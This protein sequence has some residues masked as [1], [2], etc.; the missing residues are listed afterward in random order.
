M[1]WRRHELRKSPMLPVFFARNTQ[2][3]SII[4]KV[5]QPAPAKLAPAAVDRGI[6][7]DAVPR[8]PAFHAA[9][10]RRNDA[11]RFMAHDDRRPPPPGAA[12]HSMNVAAANTARLHRD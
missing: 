11:G 12:I 8:S 4:A 5:D 9:A 6:Q 10:D 3:P 7:R 1:L 2:N